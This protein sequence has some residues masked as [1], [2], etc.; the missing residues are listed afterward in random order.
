MAAEW[1]KTWSVRSTWWSLLTALLLMAA[2]AAQL[3]IYTTDT[4]TNTDPTDDKGIVAA[5]EIAIQAIDLA[6]FAVIALAM[7]A[8]TVEY[9][10]GTIRATLQWM[11]RRAWMLMAKTAVVACVTFGAGVLMGAVGAAVGAA[12]LG[13]WRSF[14]FAGTARDLLTIGLYLA[15]IC[16]FTL[17][18]GTALRSAVGTLT[19]VF[20][21]LTI[22]PAS[23]QN[24][25]ITFFERISDAL[26]GV[27]GARF[28]RGATDPYPP[29]VGLLILAVWA[30]AALAG[31][32]AV[33]RRRDA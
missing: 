13:R 33:L 29:I 12:I 4:N 16:M 19:S 5:S 7:L 22:I 17:G 6:Q 11:P 1:T 20:L 30:V 31:G 21:F 25:N 9:S 32:Y 2:T 27:A 28:L 14:S 24:S 18:V 23:L 10:A 26:P 8:I 3:G 15:L